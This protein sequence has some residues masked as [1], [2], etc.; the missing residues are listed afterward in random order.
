[1]FKQVTQA[2]LGHTN[3]TLDGLAHCSASTFQ[4]GSLRESRKLTIDGDATHKFK[5]LISVSSHKRMQMLDPLDTANAKH[6]RLSAKSSC[7]DS[8]QTNG[9]EHSDVSAMFRRLS[10]GN[11]S[12]LDFSGLVWV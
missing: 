5:K 6:Q 7:V 11:R 8:F 1:M 2:F 12:E 9:T 4:V 3:E 10:C